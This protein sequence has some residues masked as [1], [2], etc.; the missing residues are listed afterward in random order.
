M[1]T[2]IFALIEGDDEEIVEQDFDDEDTAMSFARGKL[3]EHG[4]PETD[5]QIS[6]A[7][8]TAGS[9]VEWLGAYAFGAGGRVIWEA[10]EPEVPE[11]AVGSLN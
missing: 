8:H 6:V 5:C 2:Y 7:V 10:F 3:V 9:G 11:E 1:A 4:D